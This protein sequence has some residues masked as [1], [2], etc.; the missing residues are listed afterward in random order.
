MTSNKEKGPSN[1]EALKDIYL[2]RKCSSLN[3]DEDA[4]SGAFLGG[5]DDAIELTV[6]DVGETC[7]AARIGIHLV[8]LFDISETVVKQREHVRGDLLAESVAC[9]EILIDPDLHVSL[10]LFVRGDGNATN[11]SCSGVR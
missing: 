11:H 8:A 9:A 3:F 4:F 5:L 10:H 2:C 6:G 7:S 1:A